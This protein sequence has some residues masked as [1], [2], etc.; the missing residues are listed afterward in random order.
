MIGRTI[1][2]RELVDWLAEIGSELVVEF[3]HRD[4]VQ[5]RRLLA[6]KHEGS[7]PDYTR[8]VFEQSLQAR[9]DIQGSVELPSGTRTLYHAAPS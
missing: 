1:P 9:F 2:L 4:D 8:E 5:V 7:H 3:P 6:R